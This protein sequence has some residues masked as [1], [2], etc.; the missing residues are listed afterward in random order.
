MIPLREYLPL[1]KLR[2]GAFITLSGLVAALATAQGAVPADRMLWLAAALM[3][4]SASAALFNQYADRDLD[5]LMARTRHRPLP[6]GRVRPGQVLAVG[7]F[8]ALAALGVALLAFN[9]LVALHLLLGAFVYAV[10]YTVWLKRR[11]W[12]NIV[13]GGL[14]GSF[15]VLAGGASVRPELCLPPLLLALVMFFWTP[16]HFWSLAMAH[17][18]DYARAGI[19][20]LPV[21]VGPAR[22]A[23]SIL[24]NTGLLLASSLL[25]YGAGILGR[26]YLAG[27]LLAGAYFL[28]QNLRLVR[29][30]SRKL[31]WVNFKASM[32]YLALLFAAVVLDVF[33]P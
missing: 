20:M 6:A 5:R 17:R 31:A 10:V 27:A 26:T 8:L 22:T 12:L 33:W 3:L 11:S 21:V 23:W 24:V 28:L 16:S 32:V 7:G 18:A 9:A 2:I 30:P 19:P 4:A 1:L 25:P 13:I 15:A 14:A 29:D